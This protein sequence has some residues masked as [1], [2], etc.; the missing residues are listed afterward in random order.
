MSA[1]RY[2]LE[3]LW[4]FLINQAAEFFIYFFIICSIGENEKF[5]P[6]FKGFQKGAR[7]KNKVQDKL[8]MSI[9]DPFFIFILEKFFKETS[10]INHMFKIST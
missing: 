4:S 10:I 7:P 3:I 6:T 5:R 8:L 9:L 2:D 1:C